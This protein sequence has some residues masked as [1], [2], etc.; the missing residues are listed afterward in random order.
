MVLTMFHFM[1]GL[2]NA[3]VDSKPQLDADIG[4]SDHDD[5]EADFFSE[6]EDE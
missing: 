6:G 2:P 5:E 3:K 1:T 4:D